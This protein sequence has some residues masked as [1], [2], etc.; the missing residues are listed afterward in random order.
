MEYQKL[1]LLQAVLQT[2]I[3]DGPEGE[4]Q[5]VL[6]LFAKEMKVMSLH[7]VSVVDSFRIENLTQSRLQASIVRLE[8]SV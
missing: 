4:R 6:S 7:V 2:R 1:G 8:Q 5:Q 3:H